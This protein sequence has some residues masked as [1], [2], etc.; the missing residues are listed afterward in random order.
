M[1]DQ[2]FEQQFTR[3]KQLHQIR[4]NVEAV[5]KNRGWYH[6]HRARDYERGKMLI[7]YAPGSEEY[8]IALQVV[9]EYVG[10]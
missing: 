8:S 5:L 4:A 10:V 3:E 7:P 9:A 1:S 6:T 2:T